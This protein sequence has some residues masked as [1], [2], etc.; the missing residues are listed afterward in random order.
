MGGFVSGGVGTQRHV[1]IVIVIIIIVVILV[2]VMRS[3]RAEG[4]Q[5]VRTGT[6]G[7]RRAGRPR[8]KGKRRRRPVSE[9]KGHLSRLF[10]FSGGFQAAAR[11]VSFRPESAFHSYTGRYCCAGK[12][13]V[14]WN[15]T[16]VMS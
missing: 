13:C 2:I 11:P 9:V 15:R 7:V 14:R 8:G 10:V 3:G 12:L 5:E 6:C 4:R 16:I 1:I